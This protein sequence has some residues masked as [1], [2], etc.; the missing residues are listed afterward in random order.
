M[1][2]ITNIWA[3]VVSFENLWRAYRTARLGKRTRRGGAEFG[4]NLERELLSLQC[5]LADGSYRPGAYRQFT[6]YERKPRLISAAP[7]RDRV[8]H[9]AIMQLLEPILDR[10]FIYD[11][12][13][14]RRGK[15]VHAA[16]T[17]YQ[18]WAQTYRYVLKMDVQR[19]FPSIDHV[20]LKDKLRRMIGDGR[21]LTL[22]DLLIDGSPRLEAELDYFPGDNLLS[23]LGRR[24]GIPIGNLT[25]QFFANLY[26][27]DLDHELKQVWNVRPYLRYVDD[28]I[29][30]DDNKHR[31]ADIRVWMRERL[32]KER[33]RLH[34]HKA[35]VSPVKV[36]LNVLGYVVTPTRR[37]LRNDN[38]HRFA[39]KLRGQIRACR[40]SRMDWSTVVASVQSWIGHA[41]HA[42][43]AGLRRTIFS[44]AGLIGGAGHLVSD[45]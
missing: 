35:Q 30:L 9:H 10:K 27:N 40:A 33:L 32:A 45:G 31:L 5:E 38:G 17:R 29:I 19:Y 28:M 8:V 12:Y 13:A 21:V 37:R 14:C 15:G 4:L 25:S 43:T 22:L 39:R 44:Q 41:Q 11:S 16:M 24:R 23:P 2:R 26:L 18:A 1:K 6:I 3:Q 42:E 34:P 7:F 20:L 36:G